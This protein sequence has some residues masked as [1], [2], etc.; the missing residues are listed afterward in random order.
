MKVE[1]PQL[2]KVVTVEKGAN[3]FK[4]LKDAELPIASSCKGDGVCG[5]CVV[6]VD[7]GTLAVPTALELTLIDKYKLDKN[8]RISC[9]CAVTSDLKIS[10]TYW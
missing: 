6:R 7:H 9:Q 3:L 2:N 4:A 5:K 10:T 8:Q 1:L